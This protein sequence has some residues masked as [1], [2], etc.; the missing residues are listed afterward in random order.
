MWCLKN[1]DETKEESENKT[2]KRKKKLLL[3][4][5]KECPNN[6]P[7]IVNFVQDPVCGTK[8]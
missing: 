8:K 5:R 1:K 7:K 2:K 4:N 3:I 6:D